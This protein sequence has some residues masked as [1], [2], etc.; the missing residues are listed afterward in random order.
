MADG[1]RLATSVAV[2][3]ARADSCYKAIP[4]CDV[5][6]FERDARM[7]TGTAPVVA[8]PPCRAWARLRQFAK[9]RPDEKSLALFAVDQVRR[10]GG[11]IEHPE[12]STL[13]EACSLPLPGAGYDDF[14]GWT[15]G[16]CQKDFGHRAM[17]AT[18]LY[19]VGVSPCD[20]PSFPL[21]LGRATHCIRPTK[22]YPRLPSVTKAERE[23]TPAL[24][25]TW[26]VAIAR[27]SRGG[28]H[29]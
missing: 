6:D 4:S 24:L 3:F 28:L 13:W 16:I 19:I 17:K 22:S 8:H 12:K 10:C 26:L 18:W 29:G 15:L 2:L 7:Y 21:T 25:A 1:S 20:L 9:P 23:H 11:V 5:Y 27:A 14:G